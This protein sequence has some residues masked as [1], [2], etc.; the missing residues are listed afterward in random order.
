[1]LSFNIIEEGSLFHS[2]FLEKI[3][4]AQNRI[5]SENNLTDYEFIIIRNIPSKQL[6]TSGRVFEGEFAS[7]QISNNKI[8]IG[9]LDCF[10]NHQAT[11]I[12]INAINL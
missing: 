7:Y 11:Y 1:M 4:E 2:L 5:V 6:I 9:N 10:M 3:K 8:I 12:E